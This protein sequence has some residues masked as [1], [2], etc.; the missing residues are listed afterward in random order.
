MQIQAPI[1]KAHQ[2]IQIWQGTPQKI[3]PLLC[4]VRETEWIAEWSPLKVI[5]NSGLMELECIF[6][7]ADGEQTAIWLVTDA[8]LHG[9]LCE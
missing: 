1:S 3:F 4:P 6:T 9:E 5:S 7:E 8:V 2:A